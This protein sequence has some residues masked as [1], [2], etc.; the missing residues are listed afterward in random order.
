MVSNDDLFLCPS[1]QKPGRADD[2][3]ICDSR[4]DLGQPFLDNND[5]VTYPMMIL[6]Y[7]CVACGNA[8]TTARHAYERLSLDGGGRWARYV[9]EEEPW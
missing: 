9:I 2:R 3:H 4:P 6:T 7:R 8:L 1:P 5:K